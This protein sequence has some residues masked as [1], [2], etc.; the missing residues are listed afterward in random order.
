[1]KYTTLPHD[2]R[3]LELLADRATDGLDAPRMIELQNKLASVDTDR[4][5]ID[6][7]EL[8]AAALQ[9]GSLQATD[10]MQDMPDSLSASIIK[11]GEAA[12]QVAAEN[13]DSIPIDAG[14]PATTRGAGATVAWAVAAAAIVLAIAAWMFDFSSGPAGQPQLSA[15]GQRAALI[16]AA[17]DVIT[18]AWAPPASAA[19]AKV[20]GDVVWSDSR[21]EGYMRLTGMPVN[22]PDQVQYQLWIVDPGRDKHPVDGGVFDITA[23]GEVI[24]PIRAKLAVDKPTIFAITVEKPGGVVVSDGPL[25]IIASVNRG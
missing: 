20:R 3:L 14:R 22:D 21:Q 18:T 6:G 24:V 5:D 19:Y 17:D 15:V 4:L 10:S 11:S 7:L 1:M 9:V 13:V 2:E 12:M 25:E 8:A 23:E 16:D